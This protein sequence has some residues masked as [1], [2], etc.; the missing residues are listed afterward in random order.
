MES[1]PFALLLLAAAAASCDSGERRIPVA[2]AYTRAAFHLSLH[3]PHETPE[4]HE[5]DFLYPLDSPAHT[6]TLLEDG[7]RLAMRWDDVALAQGARTGNDVEL[8]FD[9]RD[10]FSAPLTGRWHFHGRVRDDFTFHERTLVGQVDQGTFDDGEDL[11]LITP[12]SVAWFTTRPRNAGLDSVGFRR[13]ALARG[14]WNRFVWFLDVGPLG[15][16]RKGDPGQRGRNLEVFSFASTGGGGVT[17][18]DDAAFVDDG[19]PQDGGGQHPASASGGAVEYVSTN[20]NWDVRVGQD[21]LWE[22]GFPIGTGPGVHRVLAGFVYGSVDVNPSLY[23]FGWTGPS[24]MQPLQKPGLAFFLELD[25]AP[26]Q[27][28]VERRAIP[29]RAFDEGRPVLLWDGLPRDLPETR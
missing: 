12:R 3:C 8:V 29:V 7:S 22:D 27:T 26:P 13:D 28:A 5:A 17:T 11:C 6:F 14:A 9:R 2:G 21:V 1:R 18:G 15:M 19:F 25:H 4:Y 23:P 24:G 16:E 10:P 20:G